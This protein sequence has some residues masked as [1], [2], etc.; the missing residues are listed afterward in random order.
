MGGIACLGM[1]SF[2]GEGCGEVGTPMCWIVRE[3]LRDRHWIGWRGRV[4]RRLRWRCALGWGV[5]R[6]AAARGGLGGNPSTWIRF[7]DGAPG[8][9]HEMRLSRSVEMWQGKIWDF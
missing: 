3:R 8:A 4:F 5:L 9:R 6:Q 2:A 7:R 1:R